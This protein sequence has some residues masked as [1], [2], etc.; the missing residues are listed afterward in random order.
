MNIRYLQEK[1][2]KVEEIYV[3]GKD[4]EVNG[5]I[6]HVMGIVRY[7]TQIRL[8]VLQYDETFQNEIEEAEE[9][10]MAG[11]PDTPMSNRIEMRGKRTIDMTN[12]IGAVNKVII[13]E[14]EYEVHESENQR[15]NQFDF[16]CVLILSEFLRQ[17]WQPKGIDFQDIDMIFLSSVKLNGEFTSIPAFDENPTLRF[18]MSPDIITGRVEQPINLVVDS[19]YP[20]KLW[21][22]DVDT[23]EEHWAQI[24]KVYL[25]DIWTEMEQLFAEP[26][27]KEHG[28]PEQ[29]SQ[30]KS[31]FEERLL[32]ICPKGMYFPAIEY[33]CEEGIS[34]EFFTRGYLD[35]M[36]KRSH[37]PLG[38]T[39]GA[40]QS[41]GIL[42]SKLKTAIIQEPF[43]SDTVSID[44]ELFRYFYT[45]AS[46]DI[47]IK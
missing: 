26:I 29:I 21:F 38:I 11:I 39:I 6:C 16:E 32:K 43:L 34:L 28:T 7:D 20:D 12:P 2:S 42:G 17:G 41:T 14:K 45:R 10:D 5:V 40:N 36:P 31:D 1:L 23:K 33:E 9:R 27:M 22:R 47:V 15:I 8:L 24:N 13:G 4:S 30:V 18:T 35:E 37:N 46:N 19:Y 44:A 3:I 25:L